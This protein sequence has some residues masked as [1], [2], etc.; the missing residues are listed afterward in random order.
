M[1]KLFRTAA[2]MLAAGYLFAGCTSPR[3]AQEDAGVR[4]V[5]VVSLLSEA[6]PVR[7]V[8]FT[9]FGNTQDSVAQNGKLKQV[10][11]DT[12]TQRLHSSRPQ[13]TVK[14]ADL[15]LPVAGKR[16]ASDNEAALADLARKMDVDQV[17]VLE[18]TNSE[19]FPGQGVGVTF[20]SMGS[21]AG[22]MMVHAYVALVVV[23]RN[24]KVLVAR[25]ATKNNPTMVQENEL[26][27]HADLATLNDPKVRDN[28]SQAVQRR[29][30]GAIEE[31][32]ERA[33]Y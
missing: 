25:G 21:K 23:D 33:G 10:V 13:W 16:K 15:D 1:N 24:G 9:V 17:F 7:R 27:L 3:T 29:L 32:M 5:A 4:S 14:P 11:I 22:P 30:K 26:G 12:V 18:D 8:G 2:M 19:N 6:G 31:A 20:R 28:I